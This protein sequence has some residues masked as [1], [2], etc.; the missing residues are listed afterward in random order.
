MPQHDN[1]AKTISN[2]FKEGDWTWKGIV[3]LKKNH[4]KKKRGIDSIAQPWFRTKDKST[5]WVW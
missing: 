4:K 3:Y 2:R 5:I 1:F